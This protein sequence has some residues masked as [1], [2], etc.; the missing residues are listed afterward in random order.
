MKDN[1]IYNPYFKKVVDVCAICLSNHNF[2]KCPF[3]FFIPNKEKLLNYRK[4]KIV[5]N[6][7][8]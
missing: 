7:R 3:L 5:E 2:K 6:K 4:K 8:A 1:L